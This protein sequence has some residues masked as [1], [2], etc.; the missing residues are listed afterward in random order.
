MK[1]LLPSFPASFSTPVNG[2]DL[3]RRG[4]LQLGATGRSEAWCLR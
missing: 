4:F 1:P 2:P 3:S